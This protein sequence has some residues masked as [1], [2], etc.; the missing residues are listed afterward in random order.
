[1]SGRESCYTLGKNGDLQACNALLS[2][3]CLR[4][5]R[6]TGT[7]WVNNQGLAFQL[8]LTCQIIAGDFFLSMVVFEHELVAS[9]AVFQDF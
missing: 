1:M 9:R 8:R 4:K 6:S 5:H 7:S 3:S 2:R